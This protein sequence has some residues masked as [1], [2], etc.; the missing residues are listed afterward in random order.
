MS[1]T[2]VRRFGVV[3]MAALV[4]ACATEGPIMMEPGAEPALTM[5]L[6]DR[7]AD[8]IELEQAVYFP[9]PEGAPVVVPPGFYQVAAVGGNTL[10]LTPNSGGIPLTIAAVPSPQ[11]YLLEQTEPLAVALSGDQED[12]HHILLAQ[13]DGTALDA[14]GS[15]SGTTTRALSISESVA[16]QQASLRVSLQ[17]KALTSQPRKPLGRAPA[18]TITPAAAVSYAQVCTGM[19]GYRQSVTRVWMRGDLAPEVFPFAS[20]KTNPFL[21]LVQSGQ[22]LPALPGASTTY[23]NNTWDRRQ[24]NWPTTPHRCMFGNVTL[25]SRS[26]DPGATVRL[27]MTVFHVQ[28]NSLE[29]VEDS[30]E[31]PVTTDNTLTFGKVVIGS[32]LLPRIDTSTQTSY[33]SSLLTKKVSSGYPVKFEAFINNYSRATRECLY[34]PSGS[35][36]GAGTLTCS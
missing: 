25:S 16:L 1:D 13:V 15:Y 12:A 18:F 29:K 21:T 17:A 2:V 3:V 36:G 19:T 34:K 20:I 31:L 4:A 6:A 14:M 22:S 30:Y 11:T 32:V 10:R 33:I 8:V 23:P 27:V 35:G 24:S 28:S 5:T 9:A 7:Q 26:L